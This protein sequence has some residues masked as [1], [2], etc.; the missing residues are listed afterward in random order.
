MASPLPFILTYGEPGGA[1][2]WVGSTLTHSNG[3]RSY[4]PPGYI[5]PLY[6]FKGT[7]IF[8]MGYFEPI[9]TEEKCKMLGKFFFEELDRVAKLDM[10][11][12]PVRSAKPSAT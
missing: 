5:N 6:S 10:I 3:A 8:G 11:A 4:G 7:M 1:P 9:M 2:E 12:P